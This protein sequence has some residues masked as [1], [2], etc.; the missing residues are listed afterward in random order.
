MLQGSTMSIRFIHTKKRG[1]LKKQPP[2]TQSPE[3]TSQYFKLTSCENVHLPNDKIDHP[4]IGSVCK[5]NLDRASASSK[6]TIVWR[7]NHAPSS[8]IA[9]ASPLLCL[10]SDLRLQI[11]SSELRRRYHNFLQILQNQ[12]SFLGCQ[13]RYWYR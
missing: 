2:Q 6:S 4:S 12:K 3:L 11:A 9:L 13:S 1:C 7:H 5:V 8:S 10:W